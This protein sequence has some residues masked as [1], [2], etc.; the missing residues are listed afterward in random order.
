VDSID[1]ASPAV[2]WCRLAR[3]LESAT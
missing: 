1:S 2:T 3:V